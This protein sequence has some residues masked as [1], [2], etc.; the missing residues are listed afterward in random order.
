MN[1]LRRGRGCSQEKE[2]LGETGEAWQRQEKEEVVGDRERLEG[3]RLQ[4]ASWSFWL[5]DEII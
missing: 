1:N 3:G 4:H 2:E 5:C